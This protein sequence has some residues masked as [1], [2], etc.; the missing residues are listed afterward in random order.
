MK[1]Q[2]GS[3]AVWIIVIVVIV[4]AVGA[5]YWYWMQMQN[6]Q[7]DATEIPTTNVQPTN[8][9]I[10]SPQQTVTQPTAA[11][12]SSTTAK[13]IA[14]D[15]SSLTTLSPEPTFTGTA[16]GPQSITL[17]IHT[18]GNSAVSLG[19]ITD[20]PVINGR[21]SM[22]LDGKSKWGSGFINDLSP[23][24]YIVCAAA[25]TYLEDCEQLT[26]S[27]SFAT[28]DKSSLTSTTDSPTITGT[29]SG[30]A[31]ICVEIG[32]DPMPQNVGDSEG[33]RIVP[34][35]VFQS[36]GPHDS[37]FSIAN[38][39]WSMSTAVNVSDVFTNG[40]Y[41]V[42]VYDDTPG[43]DFGNLLANGS[44]TITT[45]APS[46]STYSSSQYGFSVQYPSDVTPNTGGG[47][48]S[49]ALMVP[50]TYEGP[51][52][53]SVT[54]RPADSSC[55]AAPAPY[56]DNGVTDNGTITINAVQF[57]SYM[58]ASAAT[59]SYID[60]TAYAAVHGNLCFS[61]EDH[62]QRYSSG[63]FGGGQT[64]ATQSQTDLASL[65]TMA[66][67]IIQSFRFTN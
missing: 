38:G 46:V 47:N 51:D 39:R 32:K 50:S 40:T 5:A 63:Y 8:S 28:L 35:S 14:I 6:T 26:V 41:T 2:K 64:E 34:N 30:T 54:V 55:L 29:L 45:P 12:Q 57:K 23:G 56:G 21:W 15:A 49:A 11:V 62:L 16:N 66:S 52:T 33:I 4:I 48:I 22:S 61:I 7:S 3:A 53:V 18:S 19:Q 25:P 37:N 1:N 67:S 36:C 20:I 10:Q 9:G 17:E 27:Q 65:K 24:T 43:N 60:D 42:G 31:F 58:R 13:A 44:L 59:G